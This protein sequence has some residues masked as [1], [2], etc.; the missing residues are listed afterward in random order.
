MEYDK[1]YRIAHKSISEL[2][3]MLDLMYTL[4]VIDDNELGE[5]YKLI[6]SIDNNI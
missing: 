4:D 5:L 2:Q 6:Q 3:G 1:R